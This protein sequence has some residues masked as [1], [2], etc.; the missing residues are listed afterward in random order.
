MLEVLRNPT[1]LP[2]RVRKPVAPN[3]SNKHRTKA[4]DIYR[5]DGVV[6]RKARPAEIQDLKDLAARARVVLNFEGDPDFH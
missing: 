4:A 6:T 3:E 1:E 2:Y 5:R